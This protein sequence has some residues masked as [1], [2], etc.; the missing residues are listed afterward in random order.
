MLYLNFNINFLL[1]VEWSY[2]WRNASSFT[3]CISTYNQAT[4]NGS[5]RRVQSSLQ[6]GM[7]NQMMLFLFPICSENN[8]L[9]TTVFH[10]YDA[11]TTSQRLISSMTPLEMKFKF[12]LCLCFLTYMYMY[13]QYIVELLELYNTLQLNQCCLCQQIISVTFFFFQL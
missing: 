8:L 5:R 11:C 3:K 2:R 9:D 10:P 12:E 6:R 7:I 13:S 1:F 4:R